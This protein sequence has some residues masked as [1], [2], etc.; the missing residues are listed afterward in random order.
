MGR[1]K[2]PPYRLEMSGS[3]VQAWR[4]KDQYGI[5]GNGKPTRENLI[6]YLRGFVASLKAGGVNEHISKELGYVP[7]PSWAKIIR[8]SDG[9]VMA[10]WELPKYGSMIKAMAEITV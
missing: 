5:P 10:E 7:T 3:S 1:S 6:K 8:Q 9:Q 2:T 4:V